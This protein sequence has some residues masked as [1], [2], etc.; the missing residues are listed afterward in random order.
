[1]DADGSRSVR[2]SAVRHVI[3]AAGVGVL[4]LLLTFNVTIASAARELRA[5]AAG[6]AALIVQALVLTRGLGEGSYVPW[7]KTWGVG[8]WASAPR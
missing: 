3:L 4:G 6:T 5:I 1:M 7:T 2:V 8:H